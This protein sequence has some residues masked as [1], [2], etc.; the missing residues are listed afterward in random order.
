MCLYCIWTYKCIQP[1]KLLFLVILASEFT[2]HHSWILFDQLTHP[3]VSLPQATS[4]MDFYFPNVFVAHNTYA[5]SYKGEI[6][7]DSDLH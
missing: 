1:S 7:L 5:K 3:S 4:K 2:F 6:L